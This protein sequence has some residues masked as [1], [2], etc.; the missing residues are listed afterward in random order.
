VWASDSA[1]AATAKTGVGQ[2]FDLATGA[3]LHLCYANRRN[4]GA[5][6]KVIDSLAAG[7]PFSIV[8]LLELRPASYPLQMIDKRAAR[9]ERVFKA[10]QIS[11]GCERVDCTVRNFSVAGAMIEVRTSNVIPHQIILDL[12]S[13]GARFPCHVVWRNHRRLGVAFDQVLSSLR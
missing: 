13:R 8:H 9:R 3:Q 12:L 6:P 4:Q 1:N 2:V 10:G 7:Y 5:C 11:F